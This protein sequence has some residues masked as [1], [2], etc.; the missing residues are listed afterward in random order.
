MSFGFV[1]RTGRCHSWIPFI[2]NFDCTALTSAFKGA[3]GTLS[4]LDARAVGG[5]EVGHALGRLTVPVGLRPAADVGLV[6]VKLP[7]RTAKP[8]WNTRVGLKLGG[9]GQDGT[10]VYSP[11]SRTRLPYRIDW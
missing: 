3:V 10:A 1:P 2:A 9:L 7:V 5:V 11:P 6:A 8:T 4:M